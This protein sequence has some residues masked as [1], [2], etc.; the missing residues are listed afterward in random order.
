MAD[1]SEEFVLEV[2]LDASGIKNF[3]SDRP[4]KVVAYNRSGAAVSSA[5]AHMDARGLGHATLAF[6]G[7]PGG[8]RIVVGPESASDEDLKH[9]QSLT[10]NIPGSHWK[11]SSFLRVSPIIVTPYYWDWWIR[12]CREY[13]V[14]GRVQCADGSPVPAATV[15]IYDVTWFWWWSSESQVGCA[16]TKP[17][18]TFEIS[19]RRCCGWFW[20]WWWEQRI[21]RIDSTL[22]DRIVPLLQKIP[23]IRK[24]P[25]PGAV[26]G[27]Q[28]FES[29]LGMTGGAARNSPAVGMPKSQRAAGSASINPGTLEKLRTQLLAKLPVSQELERLRVWPWWPWWPWLDCGADII[30][31]AT[32]NCNGQNNV[33]I[34]ETI[35]QTRFDIAD[36][37]NVTLV[38]NDLACC[39][40]QGCQDRDCPEGNCIVPI[41][42]CG[43][44]SASVGGNPGASAAAAT[45]GYENP[46]G[47]TPGNPFG[48]RPYSESVLLSADPG[49]GFSADYYEFEWSTSATGPWSAMPVAADGGFYRAYWDATLN[50]HNVLFNPTP[51]SGRNV[52]ETAQH[53]AANNSIGIGWDNSNLNTLMWWQTLN[54]GF[55]NG[56]YYLR[57]IGWTRPGYTGALSNQQV[58]PFCGTK[59]DNYVVI[60]I[61]N[62]PT[63]GPGA[64]H[65]TDHPCGGGTVHICTTQP[66][67]NI[68][69]VTIAGQTVGPCANITAKNTDPV[70]I[71]FMVH[72]TDEMLA[73]YSLSCNYG[74]DV[75]VDIICSSNGTPEPSA[76]V[77]IGTLSSG[78]AASNVTSWIGP[79]GAEV[80]P[81]YGTALTQGASAPDWAGGTL[82]LTGTVGDFFPDPVSCAYQ[83]QL[84]AYKR[85]IVSCDG[86]L[87][88]N[89]TELSFTVT[90]A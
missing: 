72:D 29:L 5:A 59:D 70:V 13:T 81:D 85:N 43:D 12:W 31:R 22:A 34:D 67:C 14:T 27:V 10:V 16:V 58:V 88:Y 42:I 63:P 1:N 40:A 71:N 20:W 66:D 49:D 65:P 56:T 90:K 41:D 36:D 50:Q 79:A 75:V 51:I 62:R 28:V 18:G 53:Y 52:F 48:D 82:T 30:F 46:G 24:I 87:Y 33:I 73:Y 89:L 9:L 4:V 39:L 61:D 54:T 3:T 60:T 7:S 17:D 11:D 78:P 25:L 38:A 80:G 15:C 6:K 69:A 77:L 84:W 26:P 37:L 2:P 35:L 55:A 68:F 23:G 19:F 21:W 57:L 76:G 45:I 47:A 64:G 32:Q 86:S 44:T 74:L 83:L 8:V